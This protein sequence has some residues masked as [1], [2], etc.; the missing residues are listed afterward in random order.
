[1][2]NIKKIL[3][4]VLAVIM[5]FGYLIIPTQAATFTPRLSEPSTTSKYWIHTSYGGLNSC[6]IA[7]GNS[8]LPNC[9]GYAWGRAYEIITKINVTV[10]MADMHIAQILLSLS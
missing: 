6:I 5:C 2:K 8:V 10:V 1:M 3:S 7:S 4:L 9:V